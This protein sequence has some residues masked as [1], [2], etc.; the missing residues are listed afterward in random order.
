[1]EQWRFIPE[2]EG[3]YMVSSLGNVKSVDRIEKWRHGTRPRKGRMIKPRLFNGYV[4]V[5][6]KDYGVHKTAFVHRLVASAFIGDINGKVV[7]H[8]D[9]NRANN[10]L[11][12]LQIVTQ[13]ENIHRNV[14]FS[15]HNHG[16]S[17]GCSKLKN[18]DVLTIR[19]LKYGEIANYCKNNGISYTTVK[20]IRSGRLWKHVA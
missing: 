11:S 2:F 4:T 7:D 6:L 19:E 1:M 8:I 20:R 12:N 9:F 13:K 15:K 16:E 5:S 3:K 14:L 10:V 17:H 18:E